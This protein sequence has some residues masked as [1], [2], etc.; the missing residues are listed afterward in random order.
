MRCLIHCD[1]DWRNSS[2]E[3][4]AVQLR[5]ILTI[6]A[7]KLGT[8][9]KYCVLNERGKFRTKIFSRYTDIVIFVL[10][11]FI[12]T[13]PVVQQRSRLFGSSWNRLA[14]DATVRVF[15]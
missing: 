1:V 2:I 10:G 8:L 13:Q 7:A 6:N 14:G 3:Y 15:Q 11:H 9:K 12:V 5:Q 4:D